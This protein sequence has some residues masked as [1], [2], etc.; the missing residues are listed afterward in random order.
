MATYYAQRKSVLN[1]EPQAINNR[2]G[3]ER[4]MERQYHLYCASACDGDEFPNDVDAIEWGSLEGGAFERKV[5]VKPVREE[6]ET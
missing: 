5:Y 2:Y 3:T 1:G 6:A 4:A